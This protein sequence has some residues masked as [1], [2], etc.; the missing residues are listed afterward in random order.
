MD[1]NEW[2]K[3]LPSDIRNKFLINLVS[4]VPD[5]EDIS[6]YLN[7]EFDD[8]DS[9]IRFSFHWDDTPEGERY[10]KKIAE[11]SLDYKTKPYKK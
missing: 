3:L 4:C 8:L 5:G 9:V 6:N 2:I 10:W 1:G 11:T 7:Q